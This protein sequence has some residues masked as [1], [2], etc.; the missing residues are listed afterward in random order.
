MDSKQYL[1]ALTGIRFIA[2]FHIFLHHLWAVHTYVSNTKPGT[3]DLLK[4]MSYLPDGLM[5]FFANGW[6][7]TSLFFML[8]GFI[9]GHL[10]WQPN[11]EL[12]GG[13]NQFLVQRFVRIYPVHLLAMIPLLINAF[14]VHI[15]DGFSLPFIV[16]S[17]LGT[18]LLIQAWVPSWIP[19]W[20]WPT[21]TISVMIFLYLLLPL[22]IKLLN[23]LTI[24]QRRSL[25][26]ILPLI[27]L[28]P[29]AVYARLLWQGIPWNM[30]TEIFFSNFP[31]FWVPYFIAGTLLSR[32]IKDNTMPLNRRNVWLAKGDVAFIAA[33]SFTFIPDLLQP[34]T[35]FIR[36]GVLMPLYMIFIVDLARGNGLMARLLSGR[37]MNY[38]GQISFSIFIWQSVVIAALL[39]SASLYPPVTKVHLPMAIIAVLLISIASLHWVERPIARY[40][41]AKQTKNN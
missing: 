38:L 19:M 8:S 36:F 29:T 7:S 18:V 4:D 26:C 1:P 32:L 25:L 28:L 23:R 12:K 5:L 21:W 11:G 37:L 6:V 10:Y 33:L 2:V 3:E 15:E 27:S 24:S 17:A 22:I 41:K 30:N 16:S 31:L 35:S 34:L 9:L 14:H 39:I 40:I 20:N 13:A